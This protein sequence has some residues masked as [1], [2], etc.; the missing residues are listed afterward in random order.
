MK[1]NESWNA[2]LSP[3]NNSILG[4]K[5]FQEII[6]YYTENTNGPTSG[7]LATV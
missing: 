6:Y 1:E 5:V 4:P 2:L 7:P 3:K